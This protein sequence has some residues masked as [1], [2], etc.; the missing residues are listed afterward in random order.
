[1]QL[2]GL[3][4]LHASMRANNV[5]RT[6]FQYR[7]NNVVFDVLFFTDRAP[8]KLLFGAIGH[9]CSFILDVRPG[10][11]V[12]PVIKPDSAYSDLCRALGLT[13]DPANPFRPST[14][15]AHFAQHIPAVIESAKEPSAPVNQQADIIDDGDK[16]YF[17]HWR[18]NGNSSHVSEK[19][20]DKTYRAF[21]RLISDFCLDRNISSCWTIHDK[22]S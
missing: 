11:D 8:Y 7:H 18:N 16:V 15:L 17:S 20:L 3:R 10:Y 6:Q 1:M 13:Y 14:F 21:G 19:N 12:V 22:K 5:T 4:S 9:K 2:E